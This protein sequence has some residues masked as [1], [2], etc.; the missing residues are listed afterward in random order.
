MIDYR[1]GHRWFNQTTYY[2]CVSNSNCAGVMH[3]G[4]TLAEQAA[5]VAVRDHPAR[6]LD[7]YF[8]KGGAVRWRELAIQYS[9]G[10]GPARNAFR[11]RAATVALAVRNIKHWTAYPGV[12]PEADHSAS[13]SGNLPAELLTL[14]PPTYYTLRLNLTF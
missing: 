14:G 3:R 12:D 9:L 1:G 6:T 10:P 7:G 2:G 13:T 8:Q 5:A 11:A 4:A